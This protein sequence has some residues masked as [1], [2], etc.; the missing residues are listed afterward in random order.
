MTLFNPLSRLKTLHYI[1]VGWK[2]ILV[3]VGDCM[4]IRVSQI[5][6]HPPKLLGGENTKEKKQDLMEFPLLGK[7][8]LAACKNRNK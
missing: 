5:L 8:L 7:S 2:G 6:F 1:S 3:I 4:N